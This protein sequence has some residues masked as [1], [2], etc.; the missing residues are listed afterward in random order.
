MGEE[1]EGCC[2]MWVIR[3]CLAVEN[4]FCTEDNGSA[5]PWEWVSD[6]LAVGCGVLLL[7]ELE[8]RGSCDRAIDEGKGRVIS[9]A[10]HPA[11][12]SKL[13]QLN[14]CHVWLG[15]TTVSDIGLGLGIFDAVVG[16]VGLDGSITIVADTSLLQAGR[17]HRDGRESG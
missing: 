10:M 3:G 6:A 7:L 11:R 14:R 4:G 1:I 8:N 2:F 15:V 12:A 16:F 13:E 9:S 17:V 5:D